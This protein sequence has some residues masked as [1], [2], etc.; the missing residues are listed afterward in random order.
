[1]IIVPTFTRYN[2]QTLKPIAFLTLQSNFEYLYEVHIKLSI[3]V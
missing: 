2:L 1:M 3:S